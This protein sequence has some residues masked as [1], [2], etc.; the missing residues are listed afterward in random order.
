MNMKKTFINAILAFNENNELA[1]EI[2]SQDL[3]YIAH[4]HLVKHALDGKVVLVGPTPENYLK[5]RVIL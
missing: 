5:S 2:Q 4:Y 3:E 1:I